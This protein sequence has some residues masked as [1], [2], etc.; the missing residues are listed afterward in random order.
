MPQ[1]KVAEHKIYAP[2]S[3]PVPLAEQAKTP[4]R[5]GRLGKPDLSIAGFDPQLNT[6][7]L[8]TVDQL[9]LFGEQP[10]TALKRLSPLKSPTLTAAAASTGKPVSKWGPKPTAS[11][12]ATAAATSSTAAAKFP[13]R[14]DSKGSE[15]ASH[16]P[17]SDL[18]AKFAQLFDQFD[19]VLGEMG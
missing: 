2:V 14:S 6:V 9:A 18:N 13:R 10:E 4:R 12:S 3:P 15:A 19:S 1:V 16:L 17:S 7:G 8:L 5:V 11:S